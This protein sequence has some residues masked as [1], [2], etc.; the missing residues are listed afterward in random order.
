[1]LRF[2]RIVGLASF[3][4]IALVSKQ[5]KEFICTLDPGLIFCFDQDETI[6]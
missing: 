1:M 4:A 5:C 6:S 3:F 2:V